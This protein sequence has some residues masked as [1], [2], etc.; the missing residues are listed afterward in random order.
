ML[1]WVLVGWG[2]VI[3]GSVG[4]II[5]LHSMAWHRVASPDGV[6][7]LSCGLMGLSCGKLRGSEVLGHGISPYR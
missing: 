1:N 2:V 5:A 3:Y 4:G 6:R 7:E